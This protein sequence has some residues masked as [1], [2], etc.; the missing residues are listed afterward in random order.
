[1]IRTWCVDVQEK[2]KV[3]TSLS[4]I[5]I[6]FMVAA[7]VLGTVC[8]IQ[9]SR[10]IG[11]RLRRGYAFGMLG[12]LGMM[13]AFVLYIISSQIIVVPQFILWGL[14]I[15][16]VTLAVGG[17]LV[18]SAASIQLTHKN[19][20]LLRQAAK[21]TKAAAK[22]DKASQHDDVDRLGAMF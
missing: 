22:D 6:A 19:R 16:S 5:D 18:N 12:L 20:K 13:G 11:N 3:M 1:M 17:L 2:E 10:N 7:V 21:E 4:M 9:Y 8:F 15:S 14:L